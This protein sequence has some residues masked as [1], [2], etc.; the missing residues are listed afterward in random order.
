MES[1]N[2]K[3]YWLGKHFQLKT[4]NNKPWFS[5]FGKLP[6]YIINYLQE[7]GWIK[8]N[9]DILHIPIFSFMTRKSGDFHWTSPHPIIRQLPISASDQLDDKILMFTNLQACDKI[10][11]LPETFLSID[12]FKQ[13][14][15]NINSEKNELLFYVKHKWGVKGKS[16]KVF[17]SL[18]EI[19]EMNSKAAFKEGQ[20]LIQREIQPFLLNGR[21]F[22]IRV[23]V[24]ITT[25]SF[26][27]Y[28]YKDCIV[29]EHRIEYALND[30]RKEVHVSSAGKNLPKPYLLSD[31]TDLYDQLYEQIKL[32][33]RDT[34]EPIKGTIVENFNEKLHL[35]HLFG[36]DFIVQND[37]KVKLLEINSYPALGNGTMNDVPRNIFKNILLDLINLV[38]LPVTHKV[39]FENG[40]FD[41]VDDYIII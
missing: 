26:A 30:T 27:I 23:H 38:V 10:Y 18:S 36:Y 1:S 24:L 9:P 15:Q 37:L 40:G 31:L 35:Y 39:S 8:D 4:D 2:N 22:V 29:L 12:E 28:V 3:I 11:F 33:A 16:V 20:H 19:E 34:I 14:N 21:K 17:R 6:S 13:H 7:K 41:R 32:I 25:N 5:P